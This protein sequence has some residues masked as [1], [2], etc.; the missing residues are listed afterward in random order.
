MVPAQAAVT[1]PNSTCGSSCEGTALVL[2]VVLMCLRR[3]ASIEDVL[4]LCGRRM[5]VAAVEPWCSPGVC[6]AC[7]LWCQAATLQ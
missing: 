4:A 3:T 5:Q 6:H 1:D 2:A 7:V